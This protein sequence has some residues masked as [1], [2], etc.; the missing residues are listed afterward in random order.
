MGCAAS[1]A[2]PSEPASEL[3]DLLLA[4]QAVT[5]TDTGAPSYMKACCCSAVADDDRRI[6]VEVRPAANI[7]SVAAEDTS[8]A[9]YLQ[10]G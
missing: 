9:S 2:R 7:A 10:L 5:L 4:V 1:A 3:P 8:G 6:Y